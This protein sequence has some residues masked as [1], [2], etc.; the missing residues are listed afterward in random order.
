[1]ARAIFLQLLEV[2]SRGSLI[3]K[4]EGIADMGTTKGEEPDMVQGTITTTHTD[5]FLIA[6]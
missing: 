4:G 2:Y 3:S 5:T 6:Q 1:M